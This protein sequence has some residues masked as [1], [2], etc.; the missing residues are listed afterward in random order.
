MEMENVLVRETA[1][2]GRARISE[3][4]NLDAER[5]ALAACMI[6]E[7]ALRRIELML[8]ADD[9]YRPQH[10]VIFGAIRS[11]VEKRVPVDQVSVRQELADT[12]K[13]ESAG[14]AHGVLEIASNTYAVCHAIAHAKTVQRL[15]GQ[16]RV[17]RAAL[18]IQI[19]AEQNDL[20]LEEF[21]DKCWAMLH[22]AMKV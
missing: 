22:A 21:F 10:R 6:D 20:G 7:T 4:C 13:L 5:S 12:G 11:L 2:V 19:I 14:G 1:N 8:S 18:E 9:F 3:I 15:S 16:R 17:H